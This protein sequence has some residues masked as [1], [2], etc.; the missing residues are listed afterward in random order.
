MEIEQANDEPAQLGFWTIYTDVEITRRKRFHLIMDP[1]GYI[2]WRDRLIGPCL[3]WLHNE[4]ISC[5]WIVTGT[6]MLRVEPAD[7]TPRKD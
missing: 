7:W 1:D 2:V 5:Y 4:S 6:H 3:E